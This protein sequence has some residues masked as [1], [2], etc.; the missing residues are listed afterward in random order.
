MIFEPIKLE[1]MSDNLFLMCSIPVLETNA[2]L[3]PGAQGEAS[4]QE[5]NANRYHWCSDPPIFSLCV[6][7]SIQI[8]LTIFTSNAIK[9]NSPLCMCAVLCSVN[10]VDV[11]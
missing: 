4:Q 11:R 9:H 2:D 1:F 7:S 8:L 3:F 10:I 6:D 5:L